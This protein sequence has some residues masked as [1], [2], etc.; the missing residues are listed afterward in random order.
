M[1]RR[2]KKQ[3]GAGA[4]A[5]Q[6]SI[7][8]HIGSG[9]DQE[10]GS[11]GR[12]RM[13]IIDEAMVGFFDE[14]GRRPGELATAY[15]TRF[16]LSVARLKEI[17]VE[18]PDEV[19]A[20]WLVHRS[21][22]FSVNDRK[23][24]LTLAEGEYCL[25]KIQDALVTLNPRLYKG[26]GKGRWNTG[27]DTCTAHAAQYGGEPSPATGSGERPSA[28]SCG[29]RVPGQTASSTVKSALHSTTEKSQAW[30]NI[31]SGATAND[32]G[33]QSVEPRCTCE[34]ITRVGHLNTA[35]SGTLCIHC[36]GCLECPRNRD[37]KLVCRRI[38]LA[39]DCVHETRPCV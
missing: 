16:N 34:H 33:P 14:S 25:S 8:S 10:V 38:A 15:N 32:G 36:G 21:G 23:H 20:W 12:K 19:K 39:S 28:V 6:R 22:G 27:P 11:I 7:P 5:E 31:Q 30:S 35:C 37:A 1:P 26:G 3:L 29:R 9:A 2:R 18:M 17:E 13:Q 4:T 24:L